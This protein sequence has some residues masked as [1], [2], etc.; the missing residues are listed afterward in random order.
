[1]QV[2]ELEQPHDVGLVVVTLRCQGQEALDLP[3]QRRLHLAAEGGLHLLGAVRRVLREPLRVQRDARRQVHEVAREVL[4]RRDAREPPPLPPHGPQGVDVLIVPGVRVLDLGEDAAGHAVEALVLGHALP[5]RERRVRRGR[6]LRRGEHERR[7]LRLHDVPHEV[8]RL[9]LVRGVAVRGGLVE[10]LAA[11]LPVLPGQRQRRVEVGV[12]AVLNGVAERVL[13]ARVL[14]GEGGPPRTVQREAHLLDLAHQLFPRHH[15][16]LLNGV[17]VVPGRRFVVRRVRR[18]LGLDLGQDVLQRELELLQHV[19]AEREQRRQG[20]GHELLGA[21]FHGEQ[22]LPGLLR[23]LRRVVFLLLALALLEVE[24]GVRERRGLQVQN[25]AGQRQ[26][27]QNPVLQRER[28]RALARRSR[29]E[30]FVHARHAL[31]QRG[32]EQAHEGLHRGRGE[33]DLAVERRVH[34][35]L[36][37]PRVLGDPGRVVDAQR[38]LRGLLL[39]DVGLDVIDH[40]DVLAELLQPRG[41]APPEAA[42]LL[43]GQR[44]LA[45]VGVRIVRNVGVLQLLHHERQG[46]LQEL[47]LVALAHVLLH[48]FQDHRRRVRALEAALRRG[49]PELRAELRLA[50]PVKPA[51]RVQQEVVDCARSGALGDQHRARQGRRDEVPLHRGLHVLLRPHEAAFDDASGDVSELPAAVDGGGAGLGQPRE[52]LLRGLRGAD[53]DVGVVDVE[54]VLQQQSVEPND[55]LLV[56]VPTDVQA[57]PASRGAQPQQN[58]ELRHRQP[59]RLRARSLQL[60]EHGAEPVAVPHACALLDRGVQGHDLLVQDLLRQREGTHR[61]RRILLLQVLPQQ[62]GR[63][64]NVK[65]PQEQRRLHQVRLPL[66]HG[67]EVGAGAHLELVQ[68]LEDRLAFVDAVVRHVECAVEELRDA[69][70]DLLA[71]LPLRGRRRRRLRLERAAQHAQVPLHER[72]VQ[73]ALVGKV[74]G[75]HGEDA[76]HEQ[77]QVGLRL[78]RVVGLRL[79]VVSVL[80]GAANALH[81]PPRQRW[82][83]LL[84]RRL[85]L[86]V[87]VGAV[88]GAHGAVLGGLEPLQLAHAGGREEPVVLR[89][90]VAADHAALELLDPLVELLPLAGAH[91]GDVLVLLRVIVGAQ[92][93]EDEPQ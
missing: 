64:G 18:D 90:Q 16:L 54:G 82:N 30:L 8:R 87:R 4:I 1:V 45:V 71:Q 31:P 56:H 75:Q 60:L 47:A 76:L 72:G 32:E 5:L 34:G 89:Q 79:V 10:V 23:L 86:H 80:H 12:V 38:L 17:E 9:A 84:L 57:H 2:A 14:H 46:E 52:E 58:R 55:R 6:G 22:D 13:E 50:L 33:R 63:E 65:S 51:P 93:V 68:D 61:G 70:L 44:D 66:H 19:G 42:I 92:G 7:Q 29:R 27:V 39:D 25:G 41:E 85:L 49:A 40:H 35:E 67:L 26:R 69:V 74:L 28:L 36:Q 21:L 83:L 11:V 73:H 24:H 91:G 77:H 43:L 78:L 37:G 59:E 48:L 62:H 81:G 15:R 53:H 88:R 20:V 3:R